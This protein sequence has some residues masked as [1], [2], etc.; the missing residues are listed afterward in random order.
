MKE[1]TVWGVAKGTIELKSI[2]LVATAFLIS[3]SA[4]KEG[5]WQLKISDLRNPSSK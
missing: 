2:G 4:D 3:T 1:W 5:S